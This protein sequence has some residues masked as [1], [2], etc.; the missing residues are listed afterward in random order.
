MALLFPGSSLAVKKVLEGRKREETEAFARFRSVLGVTPRYTNR[1]AGWEKGHVEG[2]IG[3]TKRQILLDLEVE[4]WQALDRILL[5]TCEE[6]AQERCHGEEGKGV[7]ELFE[8]ER[9][10]LRAIPYEDRRCYK[11]VKANVSPGGLVHVDNSRYSVPM[12]LRGR[13]VRVRLFADEIVVTSEHE[14]VARH[15]RDWDG[16]GEHYKIEHYLGLLKRAPALL[17]HGKPFVRM[18]EWLKETRE[19]LDDDKALIQLLLAVDSGQY[20][21]GELEIACVAALC[22]GCA[23]R[24]VI[25]QRALASRHGERGTVMALSQEECGELAEHRFVIE[26]PEMYNEILV[27]RNGK[28]A[29]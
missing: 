11:T 27:S 17:N 6:D 25:E 3:W 22:A 1:A 16:R 18:P 2:T 5:D 23:T 29:V 15:E 8:E 12:E 20:T 28:E 9:S 26:S 4:N 14:E 7:R 21:L 19:R 24:A 13:G 10:L